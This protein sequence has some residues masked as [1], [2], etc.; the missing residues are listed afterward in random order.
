MCE[1]KKTNYKETINRKAERINNIENALQGEEEGANA[2]I[3]FDS[4]TAALKK[5]PN[6]KSQ[7]M[8]S[9]IDTVFFSFKIT[10]D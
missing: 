8:M 10:T 7:A 9:C 1:D 5:V 6:W 3:D 4:L 2:K